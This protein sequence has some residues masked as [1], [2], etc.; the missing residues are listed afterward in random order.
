ML[1]DIPTSVSDR[2]E[3]VQKLSVHSIE[4]V[5]RCAAMAAS[6]VNHSINGE[7]VVLNENTICVQFMGS[8]PYNKSQQN[9]KVSKVTSN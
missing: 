9:I 7:K 2:I 6:G 4:G 3:V 1:Y 8:Q 5:L